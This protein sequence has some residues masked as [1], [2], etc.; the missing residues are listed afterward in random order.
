MGSADSKRSRGE[1]KWTWVHAGPEQSQWGKELGKTFSFNPLHMKKG[2]NIIMQCG[3]HL[4]KVSLSM[5]K[6]VAFKILSSK[7]SFISVHLFFGI[8]CLSL[9]KRSKEASRFLHRTAIK[10]LLQTHRIVTNVPECHQQKSKQL[11]YH[12]LVEPTARKEGT[13]SQLWNV[14]FVSSCLLW[15]GWG[16]FKIQVQTSSSFSTWNEVLFY[17]KAYYF[18]VR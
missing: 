9:L 1:L 5:H 13:I 7:L 11:T 14:V 3:C 2:A 12:A 6:P 16:Y 17:S 8:W 15:V 10:W 4:C 18:T